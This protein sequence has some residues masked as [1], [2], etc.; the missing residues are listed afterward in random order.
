[1]AE[2]PYSLTP[3]EEKILKQYLKEI[4]RAPI[5]TLEEEIEL[6]KKYQKNGDEEALKK[7]VESNLKYV[8]SIAKRYRPKGISFLDLITEGNIGLITAAKRFDPKRKS[9]LITYAKWWIMQSIERAIQDHGSSIRL[10]AKKATLYSDIQKTKKDL[11]KEL[12]REPTADELAEKME[13]DKED[14]DEV[15]TARNDK[16]S[17]EDF[18]LQS[19][20]SEIRLED[21]ISETNVPT[22]EDKL[23]EKAR[24]EITQKCLAELNEKERAVI[25]L[26]F[27]FDGGDGLTLQ[28]AGKRLKLSRERV[29][30]LEQSALKKLR[31]SQKVNDILRYLN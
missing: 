28:E 9:K 30:Q 3:D 23:T 14:F 26:R 12:S 10:P 19:D 1:M 29:R 6:A 20:D 5:L 27:G 7:L 2:S 24:K 25:L 22:V 13:I 17:L 15:V 31:H 4:S 16:L 18:L 11:F 8:V 21:M